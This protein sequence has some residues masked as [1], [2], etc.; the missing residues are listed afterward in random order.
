VC[1]DFRSVLF[2]P[3]VF[4]NAVLSNF[5][6]LVVSLKAINAFNIRKTPHEISFP[7]FIKPE[8]RM[9]DYQSSICFVL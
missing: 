9:R 8:M 5:C 3:C 2:F 6:R 4:E 1:H 7:H